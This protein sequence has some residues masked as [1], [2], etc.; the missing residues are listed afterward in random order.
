MKY[1]IEVHSL[2]YEDTALIVDAPS[3]RVAKREER[4]AKL[5]WCAHNGLDLDGEFE[6]PFTRITQ[7]RPESCPALR[8][9][10]ANDVREQADLPPV[11][12]E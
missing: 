10:I 9:Y 7:V 8:Q 3:L 5:Q 2:G 6:L 1:K 12:M 11:G 4:A